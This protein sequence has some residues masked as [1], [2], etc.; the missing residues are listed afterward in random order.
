MS[1]VVVQSPVSLCKK[2]RI[3]LALNLHVE[4]IKIIIKVNPFLDTILKTFRHIWKVNTLANIIAKMYCSIESG[5]GPYIK[6][7]KNL[8]YLVNRWSSR[9]PPV[10]S[11]TISTWPTSSS[12]RTRTRR[13]KT[14]AFKGTDDEGEESYQP[15]E[16]T[17]LFLW[18]SFFQSLN[19]V[20]IDF[21]HFLN[22]LKMHPF[23]VTLDHNNLNPE[24]KN[25]PTVTY[26][27][28]LFTIVEAL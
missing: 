18:Q 6:K 14:W 4:K 24:Q 3:P 10:V 8:V 22:R 20:S 5:I 15:P 7:I 21:V 23:C 11:F 17:N 9:W 13:N 27:E 28:S 16:A 25:W 26:L 12:T 2:V 1:V 19:H